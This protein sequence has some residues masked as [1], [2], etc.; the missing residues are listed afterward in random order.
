MPRVLE[1]PAG[2]SA[3][4]G[5]GAREGLAPPPNPENRRGRIEQQIAAGPQAFPG[6]AV[7][8]ESYLR[9]LDGL[10][11][12]ADPREGYFKGGEFFHPALRF[13]ISLPDG[14]KTSNA[15]QAVTAV[16]PERDA[17][18]ELSLAH[19]ASADA[20]VR[21]FLGQQGFAGGYP[22]RASVGGLAARG[23]A[24]AAG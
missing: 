11:F 16:S 24:F 19:E 20:A 13:R 15:R 23:A 21:A 4:G 8:A 1:M 2:V 10:V 18:V 5:G 22:S 7:N 12:G 3:G 9:R 14:W 17:V 6:P